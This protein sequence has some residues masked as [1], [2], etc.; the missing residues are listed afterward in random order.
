VEEGEEEQ[1]EIYPQSRSLKH[2]GD[3]WI[4]LIPSRSVLNIG[5]LGV[6]D[7][8][9]LGEGPEPWTWTHPNH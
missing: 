1:I 6:W 2:I 5:S 7:S 9:T 3:Q 8:G 4:H